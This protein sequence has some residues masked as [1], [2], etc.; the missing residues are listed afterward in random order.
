MNEMAR[1]ADRRVGHFTTMRTANR[2]RSARFD[3]PT[4]DAPRSQPRPVP[5]HCAIPAEECLPAEEG[6]HS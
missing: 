5:A 4:A 6:R 3:E 1:E 2:F